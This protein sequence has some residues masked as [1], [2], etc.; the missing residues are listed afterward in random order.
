[1]KIKI[2]IILLCVLLASCEPF[3]EP[4]L[5]Q[6]SIKVFGPSDGDSS[7]YDPQSFWWEQ[8]DLAPQYRI[9]IAS[10]N[11][12][13]PTKLW[14]DSLIIDNRVN[15][16]LEP[17]AYEWQV[18]GENTTSF[19]PW[20]TRSLYILSNID[21]TTQELILVSPLDRAI[22]SDTSNIRLSWDKILSAEQYHLIVVRGTFDSYDFEKR[23]NRSTQKE[24]LYLK[25][26]CQNI[27]QHE[28]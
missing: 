11:F 20:A 6:E 19:T 7:E 23:K 24:E 2:N 5:N 16:S 27:I 10:P 9:Q 26:Y 18:R 22:I 1:M 21:L 28:D 17:G 3:I 12:N 15:I 4:D 13:N 14:T 8:N 25:I